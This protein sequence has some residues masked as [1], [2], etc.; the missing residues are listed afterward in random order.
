MDIAAIRKDFPILQQE[1]NGKPLIYLDSAASSQK[2]L[3]VIEALENYYK[4]YNSNVHRGI[5]HLS[6]KATDAYENTRNKLKDYINAPKAEQ[7]IFTKGT[8]ESINL[9]ASSFVKP[10]LNE[11]DKILISAMEHH[12]N[13]VPW[14]LLCE[15]FGATLE[16]IPVKDNGELELDKLDTMLDDSTKLL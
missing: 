11:G 15:E 6:Q 13:I 1:V 14:Q 9:V 5:H 7:I 12:A 4:E 8:T 3:S 16:V 10:G 2:P